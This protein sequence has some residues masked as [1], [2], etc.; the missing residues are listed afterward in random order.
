MMPCFTNLSDFGC[1]ISKFK[2]KNCEILNLAKARNSILTKPKGSLGILEDLAI[3]YC[4]WRGELRPKIVRPQIL[5]F[6][7]NHGIAKLG[8]S[9]FP[10]KV[11]NQMVSNFKKGGGAI[12]QLSNSLGATLGIHPIELE[13]PTQDFTK[14]AAMSEK[15]CISA[16]K[17]GW[18]N[19]DPKADVLV[20]GEMGIGNTTSAA[21]IALAIC[22]GV[23]SDW[24]GRGTGVDEQGLRRKS[25]VIEQGLLANP[26]AKNGGLEALR[27]L[28]GREVAAI[29]GAIARARILSIPVIL[30]GFI[31][32]AAAAC[33]HKVSKFSLDHTIAGHLSTEKAHGKLL[34]NINK[35]PLL[36]L[37]L[38][39]GEGSGAAVAVS[40]LKAAVSCHS[41]MATFEEANVSET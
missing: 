12:N 26:S 5:I 15:E 17:V 13:N 30:D 18:N 29:V 36:S 39:L 3:W 21:A 7:A 4:H 27:C 35:K 2:Q 8:V 38:R 33:L 1:I 40:I 24:V 11:T 20:F 28:G 16:I 23:G 10:A 19:I 6:A 34:E 9:A 41:G 31:C 37:G 32:C 14:G 22:G 25:K